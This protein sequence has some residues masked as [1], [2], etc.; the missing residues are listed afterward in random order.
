MTFLGNKRIYKHGNSLVHSKTKCKM[1]LTHRNTRK[2]ISPHSC[3]MLAKHR[4]SS[5]RCFRWELYK[6]AP[7]I[8]GPQ[9]LIFLHKCPKV[10]FPIKKLLVQSFRFLLRLAHW[11]LKLLDERGRRE[12]L[13]NFF[14]LSLQ[15][16]ELL[17]CSSQLC[18]PYDPTLVSQLHYLR[19]LLQ[20]HPGKLQGF[21]PKFISYLPAIRK[22]IIFKEMKN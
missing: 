18:R 8:S 2:S 20:V 4:L 9:L 21:F 17:L 1:S 22:N 19:F 10:Y 3:R 5:C 15:F 13:H 7:V 6:C 16:T 12:E 11:F 14:F